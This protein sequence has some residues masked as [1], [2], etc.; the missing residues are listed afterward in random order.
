MAKA[1]D[2]SLDDWKKFFDELQ[3]ES[4]RAAVIIARAFLDSQLQD[5]LSKFFVDDPKI[6]DELLGTDRPLSSFSSR[7]KTAYCLGLIS[8]NIYHDLETIRK[9]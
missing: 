7:I 1:N 5:L 3:N 2:D 6:V 9:I 4:P 8:K